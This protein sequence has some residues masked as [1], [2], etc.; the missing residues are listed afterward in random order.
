MNMTTTTTTERLDALEAEVARLRKDNARQDRMLALWASR[1]VANFLGDAYQVLDRQVAADQPAFQRELRESVLNADADN[2]E[3]IQYTGRNREAVE[4]FVKD[5]A[6][7]PEY[8]GSVWLVH[9][10]HSDRLRPGAW[11]RRNV[12]GT[13]QLD[14]QFDPARLFEGAENG[15]AA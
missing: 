11:I 8:A 14:P 15:A 9:D 7:L 13:V 4:D 6:T 10:S 3:R 1:N 12:D 2:V 5:A